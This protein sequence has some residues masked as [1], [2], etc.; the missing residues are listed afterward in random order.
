MQAS[1]I[2]APGDGRAPDLLH[3]ALS[4]PS[5]TNREAV[6]FELALQ[7]APGERVALL[8]ALCE[9]DLALRGRLE[10]LLA[11]HDGSGGPLA[12]EAEMDR[13][14]AKV[15]FSEPVAE[16]L[17]VAIGRYKLLEKV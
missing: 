9:G 11:A 13:T 2:A 14:T 4:M 3:Q 1:S 6:I 8:D 10:A 5:S 17:G 15:E 12:A 7:K 16:P